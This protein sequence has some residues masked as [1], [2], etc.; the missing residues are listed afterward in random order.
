MNAVQFKE[1]LTK[2]GPKIMKKD[3]LMR[4][5]IPVHIKLMITLRY[6]A[7][8]GSFKSLE[9]LYRVPKCTTST[10]LVETLEAIYKSLK[11]FIKVPSSQTQWMPIVQAFSTKWN[12][13]GCFGAIDGKHVLIRNPPESGSD[14]YNYKGSYSIILLALVDADYR[15]IYI[16]A[17]AQGR[18]SDGGLFQESSLLRYMEENRLG[19]PAGTLIVDEMGAGMAVFTLL[20]TAMG[21]LQPTGGLVHPHQHREG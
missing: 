20:K 14:Y 15:F 2:V 6:L 13:P 16:D 11:N 18:I 7:T 4:S 3:T 10:F 17:G 5:A 9:F 21:L 8:G 19:N 12:F 1:L